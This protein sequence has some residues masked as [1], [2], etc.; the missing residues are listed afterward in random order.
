MPRYQLR[1]RPDQSLT[2][3]L[4]GCVDAVWKALGKSPE[5]AALGAKDKEALRAD[6][7]K[8]AGAFIVRY[9]VCGGESLCEDSMEPL[10]ENRHPDPAVA[11]RPAWQADEVVRLA[12]NVSK[13][14]DSLIDA[15]EAVV[16]REYFRTPDRARL[17]PAMKPVLARIFR[18][19]LTPHLYRNV[20]CG[21]LELCKSAK[22]G[23]PWEK[24][25]PA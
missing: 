5:F 23:D 8:A 18:D 19:A 1:L 10:P 3:I 9:D 25:L 16:Y 13:D 22:R 2:D 21:S 11:P 7:K 4:D 20:T 14:L 24:V 12:V 6:L 17:A 15:L